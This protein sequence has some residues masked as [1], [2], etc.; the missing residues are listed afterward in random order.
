MPQ[1]FRQ[2]FKAAR[3]IIGMVHLPP[4]PGSPHYGGKMQAIIDAALQDIQTLTDAGFSGMIIENLGDAPYYP[5]HVPPETI[6]AM[7]V[8]AALVREQIKIPIGINVLRNDAQSAIAIATAASL[9]F[10]RVNVLTG[11]S[12]TDQGLISGRAHLVARERQRLRAENVLLFADLRVKHAAPLVE[13]DL[14]QEVEDLYDRALADAIIVS[15]TGSGKPVDQNFLRQVKK[16]AGDRPVLIGSG[17]NLE[18][19]EEL[20]A[21]ADGAIV[22]S[23]IKI[24]GKIHNRIDKKRARQLVEFI[25]SAMAKT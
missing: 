13:R 8:V 1:N 9:Q 14:A 20:L 22:G 15:G 19:A 24:D 23:A 10:I 6:A 16:I 7:S 25:V 3:P 5:D 2:L 12:V 4:L 18:N 11:T 17:L 21:V